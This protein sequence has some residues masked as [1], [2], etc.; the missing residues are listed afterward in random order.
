MPI[1]PVNVG[2]APDDGTGDPY[3]T[4][5]Q[6]LNASVATLDGEKANT[7]DVA[8]ELAQKADK[9]ETTTALAQK[10]DK[11]ETTTALTQKV[12]KVAGKDLSD[13]NYTLAEKQ[14]LAGLESSRYRG[15]FV[16]LAALQ[17]AI[18]NGLPG[19]YADVDAGVGAEVSRYIWDN[20][21][22]T[23]VQQGAP[24]TPLTAAQVKALYESN[25]DTNG[26]SD[27]EKT[28]LAGIAV[29]ATAN[30]SDAA[31]LN[32]ANHTGMQ[33]IDT[34]TN[35]Q[36]AL[37][38]KATTFTAVPS[39]FAATIIFVTLPHLRCMVWDGTKYVRA[40]FHRVG[41]VIY[42][43]GATLTGALPVRADLSYNQADYPDL[44]KYLGLSGTGTFSLIEAR[45]EFI[46]VLDNGRGVDTGRVIKS[47]QAAE[48]GPHTHNARAS[49]SGFTSG[50]ASLQYA[51]GDNNGTALVVGGGATYG[52]QSNGGTEPRP[53]NIAFPLWITY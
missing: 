41:E 49:N 30:S 35:L 12:D 46:R 11:Q 2:Q 18:P 39:T 43:Y 9:Q 16:D 17:A 33:A 20:S 21:D 28:K 10:A 6:K 47:T 42:S 8:V 4:A 40:P 14:K 45:G 37:D 48:V 50:N 24:A 15:L 1:Q 53:R 44:A 29:G 13:E 34:I 23:W 5:M 25:P 36:A 51:P 22:A 7:V 31:L 38:A 3:R 19:D 32:R 26:Y 52:I 27:A